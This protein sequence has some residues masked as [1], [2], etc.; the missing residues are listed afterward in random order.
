MDKVTNKILDV[1]AKQKTTYC[2]PTWVRDENIKNAIACTKDRIKPYEGLRT[3]PIAIVCYGPSLNDTWEKIKDFKYIMSCSGAHKFLIEHGIIPTWQCEV[4]PREHKVV[5][6][7]PPHKDVIY[8]PA[9]T[10]HPKLFEHLKGF[11]VKLWHVFATEAESLRVL[12]HG[13]FAILGGCSVGLRT[14]TIARFFG[15]TNFHIFGMDGSCSVVHGKHAAEHPNQAKGKQYVDYDGVRYETTSGFLAAAQGTWH[16]LD[17]M[18]DVKFQFFGEGLVQHM[19][20]HYK[21]K[22]LPATQQMIGFAKPELISAEY[23]KLNR[24]LHK[25]NVAYGVGGGKYAPVVL[26][27]CDRLKTTSVLDYGAGK[28]YLEKALPFPIWSY[29]PA[30]PEISESPR[31]A[32]IVCCFDTMEHIE[33]DK[34]LF[35]LTDLQRCVKKIGYFVIHTALSGKTLA[36]GRNTHLIVKD[37]DWWCKKLDKFFQLDKK[38]IIQEGPLLHVVVAPKS[39]AKS[40]GKAKTV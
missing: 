4:D 3:D 40:I 29:D 1:D 34:L 15:F 17:Q 36:D 24:Q 35:V 28:K 38:S 20:K 30:F 8:L 39:V 16:E 21:P 25:D 2:V 37:K 10:C 12:P 27:L 13:E 9:S 22:I 19:A 11:N 31:P 14:L 7:G 18:P 5:L 32:D 23:V 33:P 6:M 26:K